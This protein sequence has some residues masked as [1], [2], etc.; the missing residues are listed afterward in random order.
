MAG[1][2]S[3]PDGKNGTAFRGIFN[4]NGY[5]ITL[6]GGDFG[7]EGSPITDNYRA[8]FYRVEQATLKNLTVNGDIYMGNA[9]FAG[10]LI[11]TATSTKNNVENCVSAVNIH[12]SANNECSHGGEITKQAN[13]TTPISPIA[14]VPQQLLISITITQ[15]A[16]SVV[17]TTA[18]PMAQLSPTAII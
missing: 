6:N 11:A 18:P 14:F 16:L 13:S 7:T 12:S 10:G 5:T 1:K 2:V 9:K 8:P 17:H 3:S 4:G 15:V